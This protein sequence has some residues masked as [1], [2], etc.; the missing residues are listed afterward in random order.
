VGGAGDP[1][2]LVAVRE[3]LGQFGREQPITARCPHCDLLR[4]ASEDAA[5]CPDRHVWLEVRR[6][7]PAS[8]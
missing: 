5:G 4:V 3:A 7:P 6:S 8:E 2:E 1:A